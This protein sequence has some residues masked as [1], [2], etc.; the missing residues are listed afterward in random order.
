MVVGKAPFLLPGDGT[1]DYAKYCSLLAAKHCLGWMLVEISRQLQPAPGYDAL[2]AAR[3]SYTNLTPRL[4][5][6]GLR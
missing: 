5:A 1:A 3:K 4:K 6:A 2:A